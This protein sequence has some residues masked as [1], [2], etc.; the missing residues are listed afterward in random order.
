LR[1]EGRSE[2]TEAVIKAAADGEGG[3]GGSDDDDGEE[4]EAT[5]EL[6]NNDESKDRWVRVMEASGDGGEVKV[7]KGRPGWVLEGTAPGA[8]RSGDPLAAKRR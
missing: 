2:W 8:E 1:L 4:E 6:A 7:G 5:L 3:G